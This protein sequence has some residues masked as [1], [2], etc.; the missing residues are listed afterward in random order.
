ML[1]LFV[2][3][4]ALVTTTILSSCFGR[5]AMTDKEL[6]AY[7]KNKPKPSFFTVQN[8]SVRL[9]CATAGSDT[10]PPLLLIHGAPGA[11]Y[12]SRNFLED[13]VLQSRFHIIAMDRLGYNKSRFKNRRKAVTSIQTQSIAL[14]EAL[15]L[16]HSKKTGIVMGSSY[17]APIAANMAI[18]YPNEFH[19]LVMTA[20]AIDPSIEKFWWFH[21]FIRRGPIKWMLP[22]FFRTTTDEKFSHVKELQLLVPKWKQLKTPV[23][24]IQGG[25]DKIVHPANLDFAREQ[26]KNKQADFIL[27]PEA[28]HLIRWQYPDL[29]KKILLQTV[30]ENRTM[31]TQTTGNR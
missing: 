31:P 18:L 8:D 25:A 21:K 6:K 30:A 17:G 22:H 5:F 29:I 14:H 2:Y 11:W 7:Y 24:V 4:F 23:T 10:L 12:G 15:L 13:S 3:I 20:S 16:N 9:F 28:G 26:L 1:R 19:H 27:I